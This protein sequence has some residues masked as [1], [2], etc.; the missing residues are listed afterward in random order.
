MK[1]AVFGATGMVGQTIIPK[2]LGQQ[3]EVIAFGR[4][5]WEKLTPVDG[6][7]LVNGSVFNADE[8]TKALKGCTGVVSALGGGI[9]ASDVTRSLG[10]KRI[11]EAMKSQ[12]ISTI[13]AVGGMGVL[14]G[15]DGK[16]LFEGEDFPEAYLPVSKEHAKAYEIL[17][18]SGLTYSFVCPPD[19]IDAPATGHYQVADLHMPDGAQYRINVGDLADF[20][21]R[22]L[23]LQ[24]HVGQRIGISN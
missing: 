2:L 6:L 5:A 11:T 14:Q 22:E 21:V 15:A 19:I 4:N 1:I 20:M 16:Y 10:M 12:H 23:M 13:V 18:D 9:D 8:V 17:R 7:Q 3:A 24:A